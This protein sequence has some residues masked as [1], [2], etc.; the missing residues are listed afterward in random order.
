MRQK[1]TVEEM[2]DLLPRVIAAAGRTGKITVAEV[3]ERKAYQKVAAARAGM[4]D[5]IQRNE[6]GREVVVP[7]GSG[8]VRK[9]EADGKVRAGQLP[10]E[11]AKVDI[12]ARVLSEEREAKV[13]RAE[14]RA[15]AVEVKVRVEI[16]EREAEGRAAAVEASRE[17]KEAEVVQKEKTKGEAKVE[18]RSADR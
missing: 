18:V 12:E 17:R 6:K 5:L 11:K 9:A 4:L 8:A 3:S 1:Q 10:E 15:D 16:N 7:V 13:A 14:A 2:E